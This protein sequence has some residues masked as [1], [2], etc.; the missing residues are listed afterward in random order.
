MRTQV[1]LF[2]LYSYDIL[3]VPDL[4]FPLSA[5]SPDKPSAASQVPAIAGR[6]P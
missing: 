2:L 6:L 5:T 3:G 1:G 4:G